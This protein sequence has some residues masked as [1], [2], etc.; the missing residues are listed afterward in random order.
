MNKKTQLG[1]FFTKNS[2]YI[3]GNLL[4][5]F[6]KKSIIVDPFVG[7]GDLLKI[8][9]NSHPL[10]PTN[11][12]KIQKNI[13]INNKRMIIG[14]D[15]DK[16]IKGAIYKDTLNNP[17]DY[18]GVWIITNPPYL[19]RNKNKDKSLY[20]KYNLGDLY[21]IAL[22]TIMKAEGGIIIIPLNFFSSSNFKLR[23]E[24]LSN[25]KIIKMNIFDEKVFND[26]DYTVCSFSFKKE[27]QTK[28][29]LNS[30][31]YPNK[32]KKTFE[33]DI[34]DNFIIGSEFFNLIKSNDLKIKRLVKGGTPNS[35]I[36]LRAIDTGTPQGR[37]SLSLNNNHLYAKD[38]DRTFATIIL[39]K[40]YSLDEQKIICQKFNELLEYYR[41]KYHSLFLT[42]YRN[43]SKSYAR[44]RISFN[45]AYSLIS[46]II[47]TYLPSF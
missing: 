34:K 22:K 21:K 23:N 6:P 8:I 27:K 40:N 35:D 2:N 17:P 31:I 44:K 32:I 1:Q 46:Y 29:T 16:K 11:I 24:F 15:I 7:E 4:D 26:T 28:Q 42:N 12:E 38:S 10:I 33:I 37:I 41:N 13:I 36:Y 39:D 14:F 19:A 25:F 47:K 18:T 43:S 45:D 30:T 20:N 9:P 3:V 5:I